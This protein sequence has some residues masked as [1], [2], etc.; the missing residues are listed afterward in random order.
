MCTVK[1]TANHRMHSTLGTTYPA[2]HIIVM[3]DMACEFHAEF[4]PG[5]LTNAAGDDVILK[6][7]STVARAATCIIK[8]GS[9]QVHASG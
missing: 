2:H 4:V 9:R 8:R 6:A 7:F 5:A 1:G 3:A